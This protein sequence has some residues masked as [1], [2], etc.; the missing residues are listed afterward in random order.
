M[1]QG[2]LAQTG[3]EAGE[4]GKLAGFLA[5]NATIE[6]EQ[7]LLQRIRVNLAQPTGRLERLE[8]SSGLQKRMAAQEQQATIPFREM[9]VPVDE[10][11]RIL[12]LLEVKAGHGLQNQTC[13]GVSFLRDVEIDPSQ[14]SLRSFERFVLAI[15]RDKRFSKMVPVIETIGIGPDARFQQR[16]IAPMLV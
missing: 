16:K 12:A 4:C 9:R 7:A 10:G 11:K 14:A 15:K 13:V 8:R 2:F 3:V 5:K 6:S 1:R